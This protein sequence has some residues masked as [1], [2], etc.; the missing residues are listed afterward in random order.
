MDPSAA[1]LATPAGGGRFQKC[2]ITPVEQG[3]PDQ[4]WFRNRYRY[5]VLY[6]IDGVDRVD[7]D[8]ALWVSCR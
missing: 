1:H 6:I 7:V 3:H 8:S 5:E 2:K 4:L